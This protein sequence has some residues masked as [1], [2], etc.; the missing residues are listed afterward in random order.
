M[1]AHATDNYV[2]VTEIS[3]SADLKKQIY[4][5]IVRNN[6]SYHKCVFCV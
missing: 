4:E 6:N 2:K 1:A 5:K 3:N